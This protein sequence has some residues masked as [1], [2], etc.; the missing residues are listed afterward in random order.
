MG[1]PGKRSLVN[2]EF[3]EKESLENWEFWGK[4][5]PWKTGNFGERNLWKIGNSLPHPMGFYSQRE[6]KK[7]KNPGIFHP[8]PPQKIPKNSGGGKNPGMVFPF[9]FFILFYF[10]SLGMGI[11]GKEGKGEGGDGGGDLIYF[12]LI[13][14]CKIRNKKEIYFDSSFASHLHIKIF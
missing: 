8:F 12:F 5:I 1:I 2:W 9:F 6:K 14:F 3:R 7:K 11:P 13:Y 4:I 10:F